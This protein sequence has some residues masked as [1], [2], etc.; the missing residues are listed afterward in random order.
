MTYE[1]LV[2]DFKSIKDI[3]DPDVPVLIEYAINSNITL[4]DAINLREILSVKINEYKN[5]LID[6]YQ[7]AVNEVAHKRGIDFM[8][9]PNKHL[10]YIE[11]KIKFYTIN[12]CGNFD[13]I[14]ADFQGEDTHVLS[15]S[16]EEDMKLLK[17]RIFNF[18]NELKNKHYTLDDVSRERRTHTKYI[19]ES[20]KIGRKVGPEVYAQLNSLDL[21]EEDLKIKNPI[22]FLANTHSEFQNFDYIHI[23]LVCHYAN[24]AEN[25]KI[26]EF[27]QHFDK[28]RGCEIPRKFK[29]KLNFCIQRRNR[30][31]FYGGKKS[32]LHL[33]GVLQKVISYLEANN[34]DSSEAKSDLLLLNDEIDRA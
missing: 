5:T 6:K 3:T 16:Q 14:I 32:G 12:L 1:E 17:R 19:I 27:L 9:I 13:L 18:D 4:S 34:L 2:Y 20:E 29:E 11:N 23:A 26:R 7:K 31:N 33:S 28:T 10:I 15:K 22:S 30:I 25:E 8:P 24:I 21:L